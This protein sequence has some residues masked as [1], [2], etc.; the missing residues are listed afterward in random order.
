[1]DI[2]VLTV[3][4]GG[5]PLDDA[6]AYLDG[7]GVD[8][9]ELGVGGWPGED[10][11]DR[12]ALL[13][14][15]AGREE[16]LSL[17]DDRGLRISALATHN[18]PLHPDEERAAAADRELRE[19]IE[20]ADLL[21]VDTV[22]CF[23]G[24][25]AGA[26]GDSTPNWV[27]AP[28]PTEHADALDYQWD[29]V[30]IP[31]WRDVAAHADHHGVDVAIEM[32]PNML[33]YEPTGLVALREA[34][35]DRIGANFD[36]SHLYWQGIDVT[37]AIRFLGERDAIHH[38]HAKDTKVYEAE[39]RVKGVLDTTSYADTADR[40]WLF[41]SIG[42]GHGEEHWKDVVSTLRLVDYEGALSIEHEDAL[43]S[44]REGLEKA[45]DVLDRAVFETEPGDAYWA[46]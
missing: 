24:L 23:S 16:L 28:W 19:A 15:P 31:Y 22:T 44:S 8:A 26:P 5:E 20:L 34:T 4:L 25:P 35:N 43:T 30:A 27:T 10:H 7:I 11:V 33:V 17:L 6:A 46:E 40:S 41:R 2:G 37:E 21:G 9:V 29:E 32:H 39:S 45:V 36:P 3:P 42:Y 38:V 13:D 18:N 12:E 14:D 1:M